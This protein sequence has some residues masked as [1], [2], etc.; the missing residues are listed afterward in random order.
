VG[1]E[2][3]SINSAQPARFVG[4]WRY[5]ARGLCEIGVAAGGVVAGLMALAPTGAPDG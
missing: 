2:A 4:L 5:R 3:D 1:G